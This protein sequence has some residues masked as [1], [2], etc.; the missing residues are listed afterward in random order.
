VAK[1]DDALIREIVLLTVSGRADRA[2]EL[3]QGRRFRNWEGNSQTHSVFVDVCLAHGQKLAADQKPRETLA[4]YQAALN[5]PENLE[6]GRARRSPRTAR[7]QFYIGTAHEALGDATSARAAFE[8]AV[9]DATSAKVASEQ[10]LGGRIDSDYESDF[11]GARAMQSLGRKGEAK[12]V[13]KAL[14]KTGEEQLA[15]GEGPDYFAKFGEKTSERVRQANAHYLIGL[16]QLGLG[17]KKKANASFQKALELHPAH[18]G[19]REQSR[20]PRA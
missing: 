14:V 15:K 10:S 3:L 9:K 12:P 20:A 4:S 1:R 17:E 18:L 7:V 11:F 2:L 6:V 13:F 8:Q 19:A 5:Y 16:G